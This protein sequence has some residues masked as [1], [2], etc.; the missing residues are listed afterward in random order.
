MKHKTAWII[1]MIAIPFLAAGCVLLAQ[2]K[3][4][5]RGEQDEKVRAET[6]MADE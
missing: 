1:S 4:E 3:D 5:S 2:T 6:K